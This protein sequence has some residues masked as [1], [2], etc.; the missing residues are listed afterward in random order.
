MTGNKIYEVKVKA[1]SRHS[2]LIFRDSWMLMQTPLD[3]L[4]KTFALDCEDKLYF[5]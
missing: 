5:P 4:K 1:S 3:A 2:Q